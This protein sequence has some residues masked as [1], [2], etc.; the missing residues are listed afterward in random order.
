M[1]KACYSFFTRQYK[2]NARKSLADDSRLN[3]HKSRAILAWRALSANPGLA[4]PDPSVC[5]KSKFKQL[6]QPTRKKGRIHYH[7]NNKSPPY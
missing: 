7:S 6:R 4:G 3:G 5:G 1:E 2:K